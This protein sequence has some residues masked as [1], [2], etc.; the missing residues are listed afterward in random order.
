MLGTHIYYLLW[1]TLEGSANLNYV[2][3]VPVRT[4][5]FDSSDIQIFPHV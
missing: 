4:L 1:L 2:A 3:E 5:P